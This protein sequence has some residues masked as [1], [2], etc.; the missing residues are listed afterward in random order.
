MKDVHSLGATK[1]YLIQVLNMEIEDMKDI[2]TY[3]VD[4]WTVHPIGWDWIKQ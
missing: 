3:D 1:Y 2:Q 4:I